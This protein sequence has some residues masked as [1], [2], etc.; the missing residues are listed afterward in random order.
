M[1]TLDRLMKPRSIA[2]VGGGSWC[3][4]IIRECQRIGFDGHI[5]PVHPTRAEVAGVT[6]YA[7]IEA[8][9]EAPDATFIG[10]NREATIGVVAD[11]AALGAGGAVCFASGFRE[12]SSELTDGDGLQEQL[13]AAAGDMPILGPNCYGF[14]NALDRAALWPDVHGMVPCDKGV[15]IVG[16][17]SNVAINLTMQ[18]RGLPV[19]YVVTVGNQAQ[20]GMAD[21]GAALLSD[22]RVTALGLHI[23]GVNDLRAYEAL[24]DTAKRLG[25]PVVAMKVGAS[26]QAQQA[27]VS[28]TASLAG[29]D[30][31]AKAL[32]RRLG[33]AQVD[34]PSA[35]LETLKV[36][37]VTGGLSSNKIA[38]M[39]CSGGEASL[40]ADIGMSCGVDYPPL[41]AA[42]TDALRGAL[43]PKVALANPLDYHTYI[44]GDQAA[45]T[46]CFTAM[47]EG[48][49][50]MGCVVLDFPREDR[51]AAPEWKLVLN[52]VA[53][54]AAATGKPMAFL[55][56][57][58]EGMPEAIAAEA[59]DRSV[60][61]LCGMADGL[62][63]IAAASQVNATS[64]VPLLLPNLREDAETLTEAEA[65]SALSQ[66]GLRV[67]KSAVVYSAKDAG[68]AA[69][70]LGFPVVLKG[71]G[72]AHKTEAGAVRVGLTSAEAVQ[73][74]ADDM[75]CSDFLVEEMI[76]E[77]VAEL[78][79]GVLCDPA[80]GFVLT[81]G[82]GGV[83]TEI[84]SDTVSLLLPVSSAEVEDALSRLRCF[85]LLQGYR[86]K[87][88]A[89]VDAIVAAV[90]SVQEFVQAN[91]DV[92]KEVEINP[93]LCGPNEAI[94]VDA[95]IRMGG[96]Q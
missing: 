72:F 57:M 6:A 93:L 49:L 29:T 47:M 18:R 70:D 5:W 92:V 15:A 25:K 54:T 39:S 40:M 87:A 13:V 82:A 94:A 35:L 76:F 91:Q 44:W 71:I 37:H 79:V 84:L 43:G 90:L 23:E 88:G 56:S 65:K 52:A 38:S 7:S 2:V 83:L 63:A 64:Q 24:A 50:A 22:P 33:F 67:P 55:A 75:P 68:D 3:A 66:H 85:P 45:L 58:A 11:L 28:H 89:N 31:G 59:M 1:V 77:P 19:A 32:M 80:H 20:M 51:F 8:L 73:V 4:N 27:T 14:V 62:A 21:I 95:L 69:N 78:L 9:P 10:V 46:R 34:S 86:G 26:D 48:D 74:A 61:P 60:V 16:Q 12:A 53:D 30:A 96:N 41:N 42:Q 81:I 17:S 36:L